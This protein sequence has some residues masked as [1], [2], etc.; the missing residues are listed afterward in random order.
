MKLGNI[1]LLAD[2]S[3]TK[4]GGIRLTIG[5]VYGMK[6]EYSGTLRYKG[7]VAI[8]EIVVTA[9]DMGY[10]RTVATTKSNISPYI[11]LGL[12]RV[13]PKRRLNLSVDLG[14]YFRDS[15]V[16]KIEATNLLK[17]NIENEAVLNRNLSEY[18]W[19]PVMNLRLAYK[20]K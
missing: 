16:I 6:N 9:D 3:L 17:R 18:K 14:A 4:K 7:T 15:P 19:Y 2:V 1:E 13:V 10:L 8:N 11:G 20:L 12:G 5:G